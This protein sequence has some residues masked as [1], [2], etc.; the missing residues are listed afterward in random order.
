MEETV[1]LHMKAQKAMDAGDEEG[2]TKFIEEADHIGEKYKDVMD[3]LNEFASISKDNEI[4]QKLNEDEDFAREIQQEIGLMSVAAKAKLDHI[5]LPIDKDGE[6]IGISLDLDELIKMAKTKGATWD[7]DEWK[8]AFHEMIRESVPMLK[9]LDALSKK[10]NLAREA[11][12]DD[13]LLKIQKEAEELDN[14]HEVYRKKTTELC[15]IAESFETGKKVL[16]S[17]ILNDYIEEVIKKYGLEDI[18][19]FFE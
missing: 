6:D 10:V 1:N 9:E 15:K 7:E 17:D 4:A 13:A 2:A 19:V 12:D 3:L 8:A 5:V 14:K 11:N 18:N 16:E